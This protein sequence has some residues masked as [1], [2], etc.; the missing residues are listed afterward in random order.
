MLERRSNFNFY[1]AADI[2]FLLQ[3]MLL[4]QPETTI[5]VANKLGPTKI[6]VF[7]CLDMLN[8][9]FWRW[10][11]QKK[12][13]IFTCIT[14]SKEGISVLL[15]YERPQTC[16][17]IFRSIMSIVYI[18]ILMPEV[19]LVMSYVWIFPWQICWLLYIS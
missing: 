12:T 3:Y 2:L 9:H 5:F 19:F 4:I 6:L 14:V 1:V 10:E 13:L 7:A 8:L 15:W 16:M 17:W 18:C 11:F